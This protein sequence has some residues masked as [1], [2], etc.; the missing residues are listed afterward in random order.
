[1]NF[2]N[3]KRRPPL[4]L[5]RSVLIARGQDRDPEQQ[6]LV[7]RMFRAQV[8]QAKPGGRTDPLRPVHPP[9]HP[10][11]RFI[12]RCEHMRPGHV[13]VPEPSL[14]M[15]VP[16][17]LWLFV[18]IAIETG[19]NG[20][21]LPIDEHKVAFRVT[22]VHGYAKPLIMLMLAK[23]MESPKAL[24]MLRYGHIHATRS[25]AGGALVPKRRSGNR[26][27]REP[28]CPPPCRRPQRCRLKP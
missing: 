4:S 14:K 25:Q 12:E 17:E 18:R 10:S 23:L 9:L 1:M 13:A 8:L 7:R 16:F 3:S 21:K 2:A 22:L 5:M 28:R 27:V 6:A 24:K 15:P 26:R 19:Q 20:G 11:T